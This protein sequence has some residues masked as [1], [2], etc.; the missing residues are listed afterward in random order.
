VLINVIHIFTNSFTKLMDVDK[1]GKSE[2][3]FLLS[4]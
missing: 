3:K 4:I 2:Q 1:N